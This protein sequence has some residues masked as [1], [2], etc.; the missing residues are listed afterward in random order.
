MHFSKEDTQ[1]IKGLA[2]IF[3]FFHHLFMTPNRY[4]GM[5]IS[6]YPLSEYTVNTI[7]LA[8]K[9]CVSIFVF[10]TA[11]G[12]TISYKKAN[13]EYTYSGTELRS[14]ILKR[15]VKM[16][17]GFFFVFIALQFY[18]CVMGFERYTKIY[19]T[20]IISGFYAFLDFLG[21]AQL[22]HTPTFISTFWYMSLAQLII[23]I[24]PL[25]LWCYHRFGQY[26]LLGT[27]IYFSV[28]FPVS[29]TAASKPRTY[30]FLPV[31]IVVVAIGIISAD[32]EF[33]THIRQWNPIKSLP[34]LGKGIKFICF[35]LAIV[36]FIY[37]RKKTG[38]PTL[39]PTWN[40]LLAFLIVE[41]GFEFLNV[42]PVLKNVLS[43][44]GKYSM[45]MFL[46]H[47][48]I[49]ATWYY[50]F[51]YSFHSV[52]LI[53]LVLLSVSLAVSVVL[54][55]LKKYLGYNKLVNYIIKKI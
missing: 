43:V 29:A 13:S 51:T 34:I 46:I 1:K 55:L 18:S 9:L 41:F 50:D 16:M 44:L 8:M 49:R 11:Y 42:I 28:I 35:L 30:S 32:K 5:D 47:N 4:P 21:L 20:G 17:S 53:T 7:A 31:Y 39:F 6:F 52:W 37:L 19:G 26:V 54:E 45:D 24:F 36:F 3:M 10:L 12:L 48:F 27:S 33:L 22:F 38:T 2:I 15:Y 23:F 40:A 25:L 14:M